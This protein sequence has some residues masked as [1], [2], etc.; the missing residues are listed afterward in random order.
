M[1]YIIDLESSAKRHYDD[2]RKLED[3]K[4]YDNAGYHYGFAAECAVKL[5][6][7]KAGVRDDDPV[8]SKLHFS[9]LREMALIALKSRRA[10]ELKRVLSPKSFMQSWDVRMRYSS[11]GSV[12]VSEVAKWRQD[13]D[14]ALGLL[15]VS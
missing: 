9:K 5:C 10:A 4:R 12:T 13:A 14:E 6:L 15:V 1:A 7:R 3:H 11:N 2:G 8:I